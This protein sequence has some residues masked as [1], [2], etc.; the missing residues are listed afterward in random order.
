MSPNKLLL[1]LS[2]AQKFCLIV[3]H[4]QTVPMT[5]KAQWEEATAPPIPECDSRKGTRPHDAMRPKWE[6]CLSP[7]LLKHSTDPYP[8]TESDSPC[9]T[10]ALHNPK[11]WSQVEMAT[12]HHRGHSGRVGPGQGPSGFDP[13]ITGQTNRPS[14]PTLSC[15]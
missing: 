9:G 5:S 1:H 11:H 4:E 2:G 10:S 3:L 12:S 7:T 8:D 14:L 6:N 15:P 13:L